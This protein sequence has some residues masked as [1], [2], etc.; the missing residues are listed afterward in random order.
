VL[1]YGHLIQ[2]PSHSSKRPKCEPGEKNA[3]TFGSRTGECSYAH[4][5]STSCSGAAKIRRAMLQGLEKASRPSDIEQTRIW[6]RKLLRC[7]GTSPGRSATFEQLSRTHQGPSSHA[8]AI[9][10]STDL[11]SIFWYVVHA[12]LAKKS[13]AGAG[14]HL[15]AASQAPKN[16]DR[17]RED[18]NPQSL[19]KS[20]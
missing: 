11:S 10:G 3:K 5:R 13:L 15:A 12:A 18:S 14:K 19:V 7:G 8:T 17:P 20:V 6:T 1:R 9:V 16:S 4:H 2:A